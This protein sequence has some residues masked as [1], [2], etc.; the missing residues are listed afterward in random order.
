MRIEDIVG[1]R[2]DFLVKAVVGKLVLVPPPG[3]G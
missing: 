2:N 1:S 3:V